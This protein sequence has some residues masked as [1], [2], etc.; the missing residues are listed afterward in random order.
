MIRVPEELWMEVRNTVQ[1]GVIKTSPRKRY[2]KRQIGCLRR[3]YKELRK[4]E[5]HK[6]KEKRKG[7]PP[8]CRVPKNTKER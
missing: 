4:D 3:P 5:K 8:E 7:I 2:A 1:E 6:A